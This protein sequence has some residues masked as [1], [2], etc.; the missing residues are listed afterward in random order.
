MSKVF[1][2][3]IKFALAEA[4]SVYY[5]KMNEISSCFIM[6]NSFIKNFNVILHVKTYFVIFQGKISHSCMINLLY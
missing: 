3:L 4:T 6:Y 5:C 1:K 2:L